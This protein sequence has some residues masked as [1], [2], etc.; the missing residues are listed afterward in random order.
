MRLILRV[1][2]GPGFERWSPRVRIIG[3]G[4]CCASS[5]REFRV[6]DDGADRMRPGW[7]S[8]E[9]REARAAVCA[10][11]WHENGGL[12]QAA[13]EGCAAESLGYFVRAVH[14]GAAEFAGTATADARSGGR[15]GELG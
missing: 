6:G 11:R 1:A 13:W 14:R 10:E 12:E 9:H 15:C 8:H 3:R 4:A 2:F 5:L 7:A